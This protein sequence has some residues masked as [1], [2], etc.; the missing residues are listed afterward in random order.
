MARKWLLGASRCAA[1]GA[2]LACASCAPPVEPGGA[3]PDDPVPAKDDPAQ[4]QLARPEPVP[5]EPEPLPAQPEP[6][7]P[8]APSS[9]TAAEA[10]TVDQIKALKQEELLLAEGLLK[11]F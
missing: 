9:G 1:L 10:A 6:A 11:A 4:P 8:S 2:L 7:P 5:V 3:P